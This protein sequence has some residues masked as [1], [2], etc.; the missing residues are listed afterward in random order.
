MSP[1]CP[2]TKEEHLC[3]FHSEKSACVGDSGGP[4]TVDEG[5]YRVV[6][7]IVNYAPNY[8]FNNPD[9]GPRCKKDLVDVFTKVQVFLPWIG[10]ITG[11]GKL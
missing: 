7:G 4:L 11:I 3:A 8:D 2:S 5:G 9:L 6:V 1:R 10:N